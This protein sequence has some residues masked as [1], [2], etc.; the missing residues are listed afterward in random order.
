MR[1]GRARWSRPALA[2]ALSAGLGAL[3]LVA[4]LIGGHANPWRVADHQRPEVLPGAT[5]GLLMGLGLVFLSR[6]AVH[7][8]DWARALH[9]ELRGRLGPVSAGECVVLAGSSSLGQEILFRGALLPLVGLFWSNV[10]FALLH[11]G[12]GARFVPWTLFSFAAGVMFGQLFL[13]SGDLTGAVVAHFTFNL[14]NLR[15]LARNELP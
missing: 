7:R 8:F 12:P 10:V 4:S 2:L 5:A 15:H 9:R 1:A 3:G 14:L 11:I 13:W 6:L